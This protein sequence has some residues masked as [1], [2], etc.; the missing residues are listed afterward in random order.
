M[1]TTR[2]ITYTSLDTITAFDLITDEYLFTLD[3]LQDAT[4]A[5][6]EDKEDIVGKGGRKINSIKKNKAVTVSGNNGLI[7][8]GLL[9]LQTGGEFVDV[10]K[11]PVKWAER[12]AITNNEATTTYKAV[13]T[14][15]NEIGYAYIQNTDNTSKEKLTQDASSASAGKFT[16][17][18]ETKKITFFESAYTDG[19]VVLVYYMRNIPAHVVENRSDTYS[20]KCKL[21]IDATGEDQCGQIYHV[22]FLIPRADF[23]GTFDMQFGDTQSMHAFEASSLTGSGSGCGLTSTGDAGSL[24]TY[25]VFANGV[26]DAT[27]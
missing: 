12:L 23:S 19:T 7:S 11:A 27:E 25:T 20:K 22:Q 24:W 18:P 5:N 8:G 6:S 21:Y 13:G 4:I 9:A 26:E 10:E 14:T 2:D 16:Y 15:G 3:E 1:N 17:D